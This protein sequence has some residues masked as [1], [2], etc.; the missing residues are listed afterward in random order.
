LTA[1][2]VLETLRMVSGRPAASERLTRQDKLSGNAAP[3]PG[4]NQQLAVLQSLFQ[5]CGKLDPYF[6]VKL[7]L[8]KA[9][10]GFEYDG[11]AI[12]G[13]IGK[14]F[15][16]DDAQVA[17]AVALTDTFHV[18]RLLE[19]KGRDGLRDVTLRPLVPVRPALA[20]AVVD[21]SARYPMWVERKYDGIRLTL[22]KSTDALG[23]ILCGAYTRNRLDWLEL[24]PG[25]D[26]TIG[27]LPAKNV[28]IDGELY[29]TVF[30]HDGNR[31]ANVYEVYAA[32][33]G[34]PSVPVTLRFAGFDILYYEGQDLTGLPLSERRR[35][36]VGVLNP[37]AQFGGTPVSVTV[38]DGQ[39]AASKD[40]VNRLYQHFRG[41]ATKCGHRS[42]S[43]FGSRESCGREP[44]RFRCA[45]RN[46]WLSAPTRTHPKSISQLRWKR[47]TSASVSAKQGH[48]VQP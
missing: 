23:G 9:G 3:R 33:H 24:V 6:L 36:L 12:C 40:D 41:R 2:E 48:F 43:R 47:S 35:F 44:A 5:R 14:Q 15:A 37:L 28:I 13:L 1:A 26:A 30:T 19:A 25:L 45:T 8:R 4:R 17:H 18:I 10:F 7:I 46:C 38:A 21:A 11:G 42:W 32:L 16:V 34:Q 20:S 22:H 31:P 29:G 39:L 27:M